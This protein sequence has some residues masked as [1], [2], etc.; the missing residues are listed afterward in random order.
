MQQADRE[1]AKKESTFDT[2]TFNT[3]EAKQFCL[4]FNRYCRHQFVNTMAD[5]QDL[6][7]PM[8]C[9]D[10]FEQFIGVWCGQACQQPKVALPSCLPWS[11]F[12]R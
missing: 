9:P 8:I 6:T 5:Y 1:R 3:P 10:D 11:F 2:Q 4:V 7:L 12:I